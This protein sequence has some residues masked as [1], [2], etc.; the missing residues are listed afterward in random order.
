MINI[1]MDCKPSNLGV[2]SLPNED[3]FWATLSKASYKTKFLVNLVSQ[4]KKTQER[5]ANPKQHRNLRSHFVLTKSNKEIK[6][7]EEI[8]VPD[9]QVWRYK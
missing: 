4:K 6:K 2:Y 9:R 1:S 8:R 7:E 3:F 5:K